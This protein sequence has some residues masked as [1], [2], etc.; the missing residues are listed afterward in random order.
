MNAPHPSIAKFPLGQIVATSTALKELDQDD[1]LAA[2][3]RHQAGDWGELPD[4]DRQE[5]ELSLQQGFPLLSA[6]RSTAGVKFWIITEAD[7][8]VTTVLLP[9]D[10]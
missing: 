6:Y 5:N 2:I 10:Y 4:E 9:E 7:R 1:I 8:S 3:Q